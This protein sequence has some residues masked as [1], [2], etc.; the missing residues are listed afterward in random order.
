[1][2]KTSIT[3]TTDFKRD[4]NWLEKFL[5]L[6]NGISLY[7]HKPV[8]YKLELDVWLTGLGGRWCELVY[9]LAVPRGYKNCSIVHLEMG[10]VY[11]AVKVFASS[12]S[13]RKVLIRCDNEAVVT[14]LKSGKN[15]DPYLAAVACNVWY[16]S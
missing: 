11:L 5:P 10:N 1:M 7:D 14:V 4:L 16:I 3:L 6:Y 2:L 8:D 12:W 9:H 15:K 13:G